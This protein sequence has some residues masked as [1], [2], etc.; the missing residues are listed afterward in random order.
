MKVFSLDKLQ[1]YKIDKSIHNHFD[2]E[3][4]KMVQNDHLPMENYMNV[5]LKLNIDRETLFICCFFFFVG[6]TFG[7]LQNGKQQN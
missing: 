7:R 1:S 5:E 6:R 4:P 3:I 2:F